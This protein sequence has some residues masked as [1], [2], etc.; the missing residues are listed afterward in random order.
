M[1][2]IKKYLKKKKNEHGGTPILEYAG[3]KTK[4]YKVIDVNNH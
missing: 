2:I 3:S 1:L 4:S